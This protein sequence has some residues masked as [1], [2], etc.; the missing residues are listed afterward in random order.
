VLAF[1]AVVRDLSPGLYISLPLGLIAVYFF[2]VGW[3]RTP[4]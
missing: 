4:V 2:I 3:L 1:I